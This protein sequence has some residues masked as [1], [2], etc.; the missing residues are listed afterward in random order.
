MLSRA[1]PLL[2][3]AD[4]ALSV[5]AGHSDEV[6]SDRPDVDARY[7]VNDSDF[8]AAAFS[9]KLS[10]ISACRARLYPNH[11]PLNLVQRGALAVFSAFGAALR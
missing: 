4:F 3:S 1:G 6:D 5:A 11:E 2:R 7:S 10:L 8:E 9:L